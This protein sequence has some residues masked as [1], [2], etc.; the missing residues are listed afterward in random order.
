MKEA[1]KMQAKH[2]QNH[3][4]FTSTFKEETIIE[5]TA[6]I[7]AWNADNRKPNPYEDKPLSESV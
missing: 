6:D 3:A 1:H 5:W 4:L 2:I 7:D